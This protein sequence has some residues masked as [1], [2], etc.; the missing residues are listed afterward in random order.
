M[1]DRHVNNIDVK[2]A[3]ELNL[4]LEALHFAFRSITAQPDAILAKQGMGRAHHRIL[5]MLAHR[6]ELPMSELTEIL[7]ISRQALHRP[8]SDLSKKGYVATRPSPE[9]WRVTLV[10]LTA[11]G[12]NL[13]NRLSGMQREQMA[14]AF[15]AAGGKA[16][17]AWFAI[18]DSLGAPL[19]K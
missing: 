18:M 5:F 10:D 19:R 12:R 1:A 11:A 13:E 3:E 2:R 8:L 15:A 6:G 4:A 9:H 7:G 17:K 16:E 14:E